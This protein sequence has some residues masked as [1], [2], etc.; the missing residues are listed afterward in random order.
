MGQTDAKDGPS[1]L[2]AGMDALRSHALLDS[3]SDDF[4][5]H[6]FAFDRSAYPIDANELDTLQPRGTATEFARSVT[7]AMDSLDVKGEPTIVRE[8]CRNEFCC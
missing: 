7:S 2:T 5:L 1:R 8:V 6:W 3:L 4:Q